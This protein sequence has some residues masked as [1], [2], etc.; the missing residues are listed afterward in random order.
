MIKLADMIKLTDIRSLL[1]LSH[2]EKWERVHGAICGLF[3]VGA[4]L[5]P[6]IKAWDT[7]L[8]DL[9]VFTQRWTPYARIKQR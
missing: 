6:E 8:S 9:S 7:Y 3:T 1:P 4:H 2:K 5:F